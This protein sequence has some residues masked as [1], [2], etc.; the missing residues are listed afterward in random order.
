M[1][2]IMGRI[3]KKENLKEATNQATAENATHTTF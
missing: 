3:V 1:A 2:N